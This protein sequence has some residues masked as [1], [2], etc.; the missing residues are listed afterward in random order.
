MEKASIIDQT[1]ASKSIINRI[2]DWQVLDDLGS[3]HY[4]ILFTIANTSIPT[5]P[6][7]SQPKFNLTKASWGKFSIALKSQIQQSRVPQRLKFNAS[8]LQCFGLQYLRSG[9]LLQS[10]FLEQAAEDL[11][12]LSRQ[13]QVPLCQSNIFIRDQKIVGTKN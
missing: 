8:Y 3:D 13:L 6:S 10:E 9:S 11:Q 7:E 4:G 1:F 12:M 5:V 2:I